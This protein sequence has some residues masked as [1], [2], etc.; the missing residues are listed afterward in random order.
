MQPPLPAGK[1]RGGEE[2][3]PRLPLPQVRAEVSAAARA[4]GRGLSGAPWLS[5][6]RR[7]WQQLPELSSLSRSLCAGLSPHSRER[8]G[9]KAARTDD[10][11]HLATALLPHPF[12]CRPAASSAGLFFPFQSPRP[13][14]LRRALMTR[15][16]KR[17]SR[18][19]E[20]VGAPRA[21]GVAAAAAAASTAASE[22]KGGRGGAEWSPSCRLILSPTRGGREGSLFSGFLQGRW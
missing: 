16:R 22:Q 13:G 18:L 5:R 10:A 15:E 17:K 12:S 14:R 3:R 2:R 6:S 19:G 1:V 9:R 7:R 4:R 8:G 20:R 11:S 21:A